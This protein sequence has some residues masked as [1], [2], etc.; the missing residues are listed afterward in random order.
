MSYDVAL[1]TS[2]YPLLSELPNPVVTVIDFLEQANHEA[3]LV[4]GFVR[5]AL[6]GV[7][8]HDADI[9]TS[10]HWEQV[11][12][13]A[14]EHGCAVYETGTQHGT[15]TVVCI[16]FFTGAFESECKADESVSSE[17]LYSPD[18]PSVLSMALGDSSVLLCAAVAVSA[19]AIFVEVFSSANASEGMAVPTRQRQRIRASILLGRVA[20]MRYSLIAPRGLVRVRN[21]CA[22]RCLIR[23]GEVNLNA[24][25]L[26]NIKK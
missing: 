24:K 12:N 19:L 17:V 3:W 18:V 23:N 10:A 22:L 9:A 13:L 2:A 8:P 11:K 1:H 20:F 16:S 14:L 15:V 26:T 7:V 21:E 25:S 6:R 5:D 4:G